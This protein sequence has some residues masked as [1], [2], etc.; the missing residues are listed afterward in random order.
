MQLLFAT[1]IFCL[2]AHAEDYALER[3]KAE[4]TNATKNCRVVHS[5][6]HGECGT[7]LISCF[8]YSECTGSMTDISISASN[9]PASETQSSYRNCIISGVD[10]K[11]NTHQEIASS[12]NTALIID[13]KISGKLTTTI[14]TKDGSLFCEQAS[15]ATQSYDNCYK[16]MNLQKDPQKISLVSGKVM[17]QL[18]FKKT[19]LEQIGIAPIPLERPS[20]MPQVIPVSQ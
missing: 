14:V 13:A 15:Q 12:F 18:Y 17:N 7:N 16:K 11:G 20:P 8:I 1:L 2:N 19:E 3:C 6:I 10:P 4:R 9:V 5:A